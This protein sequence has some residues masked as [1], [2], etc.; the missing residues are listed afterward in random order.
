MHVGS[1]PLHRPDSEDP[2]DRPAEVLVD[3]VG[4]AQLYAHLEAAVGFLR[5]EPGVLV[6]GRAEREQCP[7]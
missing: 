7:S 4:L 6:A 1:H 3:V 2:G 5:A